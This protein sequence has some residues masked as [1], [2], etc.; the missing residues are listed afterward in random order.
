MKKYFNKWLVLV[1]SSILLL[2]TMN[3]CVK[4]RNDLETD[5]SKLQDFV[6]L[7]SAGLGN[8]AS[9]GFQ[10]TPDSPD[11]QRFDIIVTLASKNVAQSDIK[12]TLGVT[13]PNRTDYNAA[14]GTTYQPF[15]ASMYRIV[16]PVVTIPKGQN[17][18]TA[19]VEVYSKNGFDPTV[20]YLLPVSIIDA[21]GKNL[22]SNQNTKYYH[23]IGNPLA[24]NYTWNF[25]RFNSSDTNS[26]QN[27]S[28][29]VGHT[30]NIGAA[31]AS[32]LLLPDSYLQTFVGATAG[33]TLSFTNNNG[34][35]SNFQVAFDAGTKSGLASGG[36]TVLVNPILVGYNIVGTAATKYAGSSF[37]TYFS[38]LNSS[39]G[40]RTLID[41]FV[42]Q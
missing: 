14:N 34:V 9:A 40:T 6:I 7:Q 29:F 19:T 42:K 33:V 30:V 16:T 20:S 27:A 10:V 15:T 31:S 39:G 37:R 8:F 24:G 38:L 26:A 41:N 12:V 23:V 21:S 4:N 28:S 36:F 1:L 2:S 35:F 25:T 11:T 32:S 22:S 18:A 13:D 5:F 17:Y 3:S